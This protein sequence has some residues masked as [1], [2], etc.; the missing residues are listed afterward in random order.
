M[1]TE[2]RQSRTV[3]KAIKVKELADTKKWTRARVALEFQNAAT[4]VLHMNG[5]DAAS[6]ILQQNWSMF[7]SVPLWW[8]V[9]TL[10]HFNPK[11]PPITTDPDKV[12]KKIEF[13]LGVWLDLVD[14]IKDRK[15]ILLSAIGLSHRLIGVFYHIRR[16]T[17]SRRHSKA[18]DMLV[19]RLN[20]EKY[21]D[22][23]FDQ[24]HF[25]EFLSQV[26]D[27]Q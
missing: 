2:N 1:A 14:S 26:S 9:S 3:Q 8:I 23:P 22:N 21:I 6:R 10:G 25:A 27:K 20:H 7:Y 19:Y 24:E 13:V 4:L 15:I 12:A 16:Q 5:D 17:V 11:Q 18:L